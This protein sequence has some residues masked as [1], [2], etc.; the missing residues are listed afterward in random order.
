MIDD[1]TEVIGK[2]YAKEKNLPELYKFLIT[3]QM[4]ERGQIITEIWS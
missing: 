2:I 1:V 4:K 3:K